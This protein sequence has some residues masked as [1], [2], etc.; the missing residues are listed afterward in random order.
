MV[1][2]PLGF[3]TVFM[4]HRDPMEAGTKKF[5]EESNATPFINSVAVGCLI[6]IAVTEI[7]PD[8]FNDVGHK[9]KSIVKYAVFVVTGGLLMVLINF[10]HK[11]D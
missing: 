8:A 3:F 6:Y 4:I 11:H 7:V 5:M 10:L 9:T 2:N 1:I